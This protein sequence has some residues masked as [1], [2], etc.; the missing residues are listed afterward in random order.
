M[1]SIRTLPMLAAVAMLLVSCATIPTPQS[2]AMAPVACSDS[3]Y[4]QLSRQHPDSLSE[5]SWQRL[6][7]LE[8]ACAAARAQTP[9]EESS[10]MGMMGM[11]HGGR[12]LWTGVGMLFVVGMAITMFARR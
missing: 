3:V 2:H 11:D 8:R 9:T 5:R 12:G 6:Q 10:G 4:V 7:S 1:R